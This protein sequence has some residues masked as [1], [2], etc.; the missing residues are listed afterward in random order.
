MGTSGRVTSESINKLEPTTTFA[1]EVVECALTGDSAIADGQTVCF[2]TTICDDCQS[3]VLRVSS[4]KV[5]RTFANGG[6][7]KVCYG[8]AAV[9]PTSELTKQTT[10][11]VQITV[12]GVT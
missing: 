5:N 12:I 10:T 9:T 11:G 3:D 6:I 4:S 1:N 8:D 7:F 2:T